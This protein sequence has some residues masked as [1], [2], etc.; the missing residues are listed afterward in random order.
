MSPL[1]EMGWTVHEISLLFSITA[2]DSIVISV[3]GLSKSKRPQ[4]GRNYRERIQW[5]VRWESQEVFKERDNA[6]Y[7]S[8]ALFQEREKIVGH[9]FYFHLLSSGSPTFEWAPHGHHCPELYPPCD[10]LPF[11]NGPS[12]GPRRPPVKLKEWSFHSKVRLPLDIRGQ[13]S[14]CNQAEMILLSPLLSK[15]LGKKARLPTCP[16]WDSGIQTL[17]LGQP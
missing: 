14:S 11:D 13:I 5:V 1:A 4:K 3:K 8:D 2:C 16:V 15:L 10:R 6:K 12:Q 17:S 7:I 9:A